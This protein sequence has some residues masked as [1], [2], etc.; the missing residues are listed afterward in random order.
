MAA[1][2][3]PTLAVALAYPY[4]HD[5]DKPK[6]QPD[7]VIELPEAEARRLIRDGYARPTTTKES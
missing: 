2:K 1:K 3:E 4:P 6:H 5:S 7:E